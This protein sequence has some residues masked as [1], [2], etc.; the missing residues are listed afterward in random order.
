[1]QLQETINYKL[2]PSVAIQLLISCDSTPHLIKYLEKLHEARDKSIVQQAHTNL[3]INC[4]M[5]T[6]KHQLKT[7][8]RKSELEFARTGVH[9]F[10]VQQLT[11]N[12][13]ANENLELAIEC[14]MVFGEEMLACKLLVD[15]GRHKEV[16]VFMQTF[17]AALAKEVAVNFGYA[18][19][20]NGQQKAVLD[21]I[22]KL[23]LSY[24][25]ESYQILYQ[26]MPPGWFDK[27]IRQKEAEISK[28]EDSASMHR[29][30]SQSQMGPVTAKAA[31]GNI[32]QTFN[33]IKDIGQKDSFSVQ[34]QQT[35]SQPKE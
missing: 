19:I 5:K 9:G 12:L 14:A 20:K 35:P 16:A 25:P 21:T 28:M 23:C 29:A 3:L 8:L 22:Q 15:A 18:L 33:K 2:E 13:I 1:M 17:P 32:F 11:Q 24:Q 27:D 4:Y 26:L 10:D 7:F 34:Q 30:E 6:D 31:I